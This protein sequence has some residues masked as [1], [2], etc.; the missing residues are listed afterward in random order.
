MHPRMQTFQHLHVNSLAP[1][2]GAGTLRC[3]RA[4]VCCKGPPVESSLHPRLDNQ[5]I[6]SALRLRTHQVPGGS[7]EERKT[8]PRL[9]RAK[10]VRRMVR[11]PAAH[12]FPLFLK[13]HASFQR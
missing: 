8:L 4:L 3:I 13:T 1:P 11:G 7:S 10:V 2:P 6:H 9:V 5:Q 12:S